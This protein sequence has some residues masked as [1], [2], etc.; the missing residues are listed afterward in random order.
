MKNDTMGDRMKSY[1]NQTCGIKMLPLIPV[2]ACTEKLNK[3]ANIKKSTT[4]KFIISIFLI[5]D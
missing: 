2:V 4:L 1:E 5:Y 3:A